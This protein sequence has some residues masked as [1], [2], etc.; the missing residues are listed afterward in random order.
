MTVLEIA[1]ITTT[2]GSGDAFV[3]AY[4]QGRHLLTDLAECQSV[5]MTRGVESPDTFRLLVVW[6]SVEAHIEKFRNDEARYAEWRGLIGPHF[7][8]PPVVEHY[9]DV[10]AG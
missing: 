10:D 4:R 8:E 3:A 1:H 6:D 7:A 2:P 5:T 9:V